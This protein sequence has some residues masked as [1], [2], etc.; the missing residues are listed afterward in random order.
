MDNITFSMLLTQIMEGSN[1][2]FA[3][4]A[5]QIIKEHGIDISYPTFANY[6]SFSTVPPY[7]VARQILDCFDYEC[8]D[9]ELVEILDYSN[10]ELKNMRQDERKSFKRT[11]N[12]IPK[13][14]EDDL[15]ADSLQTLLEMRAQDIYGE[16]ANINKYINYLV[17]EDLIKHGLIMI[18]ED[19]S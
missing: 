10:R 18:K 15:S 8:T 4:T 12:L 3:N 16:E 17:Y 7:E 19:I 6:K 1:I 9:A 11:I 5:Y 13:N 2:R 14:F